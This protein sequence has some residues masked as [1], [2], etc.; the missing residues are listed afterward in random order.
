MKWVQ[1][2]GTHSVAST[3]NPSFTNSPGQLTPT[4]YTHVFNSA[5]TYTYE[6]GVHGAAMTG[7][8]VVQ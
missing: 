2:N 6:C 3:G 5:G 8:V 1:V 7:I 4:G